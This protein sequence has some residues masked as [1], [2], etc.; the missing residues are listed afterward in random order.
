MRVMTTAAYSRHSMRLVGVLGGGLGLVLVLA[1]SPS[2]SQA[3][4]AET[5]G[6]GNARAAVSDGTW[7]QAQE[8]PGTAALNAG[9][10]A[11]ITSVS[12]SQA[13]YCSAGGAYLD[14]SGQQQ[15]FVVSDA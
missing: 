13:G 5:H 14:A 10:Q 3:S 12:C 2:A 8:V 1:A 15:A 11:A 7:G 9:G 4:V 6:A